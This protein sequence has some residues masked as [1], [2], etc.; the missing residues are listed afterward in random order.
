MPTAVPSSSSGSFPHSSTLCGV[1]GQCPR[2]LLLVRSD[3][4]LWDDLNRLGVR[5]GLAWTLLLIV[6][7]VWRLAR[8][9]PAR[10]LVIAPVLVAGSLYLALLWL[11]FAHSL[12]A[13]T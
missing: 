4:S 12:D 5:L 9:T 3:E 8:S 10:R 1:C 11:A 6:L 2:N 7:A 13:A